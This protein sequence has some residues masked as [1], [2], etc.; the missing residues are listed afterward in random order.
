MKILVIDDTEDILDLISVHLTA[1]GHEV[2]TANN[3]HKGIEMIK[4]GTFDVVLLD[5]AMPE[6]SGLNVI[7]ALEKEGLINTTK[8]LIITAS[9]MSSTKLTNLMQRGV[10]AWMRK[11]INFDILLDRLKNI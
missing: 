5:I 8:V 4:T 2:I 3:G 6:F 11:P 9:E 1:A 10:K 7:D